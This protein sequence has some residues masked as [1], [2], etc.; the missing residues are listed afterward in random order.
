[1]SKSNWGLHQT[2]IFK[3][4]K[5]LQSLQHVRRLLF[6]RPHFNLVDFSPHAAQS[7]TSWSAA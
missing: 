3:F 6:L 4:V 1:M 5:W 7:E 2:S